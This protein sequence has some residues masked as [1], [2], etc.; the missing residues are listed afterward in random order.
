MCLP[1]ALSW[2]SF[3][4]TVVQTT[5]PEKYSIGFR[6]TPGQVIPEYVGEQLMHL[7]RP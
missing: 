3:G 5:C 7:T 1:R 2:M 6:T 4:H